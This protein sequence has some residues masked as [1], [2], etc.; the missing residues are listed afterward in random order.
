MFVLSLLLDGPEHHG[1]HPRVGGIH[2]VDG[3][4]AVVRQDVAVGAVLKQMSEKCKNLI[5]SP[6][7]CNSFFSISRISSSKFLLTCADFGTCFGAPL[8]KKGFWG[9][10]K[11]KKPMEISSARKLLRPVTKFKVAK[12]NQSSRLPKMLLAP[13]KVW[14][15]NL[16]QF[17]GGE[18][19]KKGF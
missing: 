13:L 16:G 17:C 9:V 4:F 12:T 19:F 18:S 6:K 14:K 15:R 10:R 7:F 8:Q 2:E 3:T 11:K 1:D 5:D